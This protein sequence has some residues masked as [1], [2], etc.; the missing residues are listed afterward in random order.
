MKAYNSLDYDE[1]IAEVRVAQIGSF[2]NQTEYD[3]M[4]QSYLTF[5]FFPAAFCLSGNF[6]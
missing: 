1:F 6:I 4:Y 5:S 3:V 2:S